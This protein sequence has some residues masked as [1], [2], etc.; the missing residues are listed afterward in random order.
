MHADYEICIYQVLNLYDG[1]RGGS[2]QRSYH[3]QEVVNMFDCRLSL[4]LHALFIADNVMLQLHAVQSLTRV[5]CTASLL[6][7]TSTTPILLLHH[8]LRSDGSY[9]LNSHNQSKIA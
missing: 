5:C 4:T 6:N 9:S 1:S 3:L 8:T 7:P 2:I